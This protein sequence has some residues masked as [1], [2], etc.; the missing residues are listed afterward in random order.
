MSGEGV[1][2]S[3]SWQDPRV[4]SRDAVVLR[5]VLERHGRERGEQLF[6][7]FADGSRWTYRDAVEAARQ[8]AS[9]FA[10]LGVRQGHRV[11]SWL[12][13]GAD[14]LRVW[15][16]ANWL[17]A[18]YVP[19]NTAYRGGLLEHVIANS[20]AELLVC[21]SSLAPRLEGVALARLTTA[22]IAD[23]PA[24]GAITRLRSLG[25]GVLCEAIDDRLLMLP[26]PIEPWDEQSIIYTSGTTGPSKGVLSSYCHLATSTL[27]AFEDKDAPGMRYLLTLPLFHA[28]G[29]MGVM[30]MLLLGRSVAIPE[31]FETDR[32]WDMVRATGSTCC[33]LLGAMASFLVRQPPAAGEHDHGLHWCVIIPYTED[34]RAFSMRFGTD[35]YCM[36]NMTEVSV[37]LVSPPNPGALGSCGRIRVG[38]EARLVDANDVEVA[39]GEV[40]E[41]MLR[42][43]RPWSMNHGYNAMPDATAAAW[44]NGWFHTGD[45]F[46][47]DAA[48]DFYF[49]DRVKDAIRRRGENIS[50]FEVE[51]ECLAHPEI[52]EAAAVAVPSEYGEDEVM[53]VLAPV[54]GATPDPVGI[55]EFLRPRMAHFMLPR[56]LRFMSELP[57][58]PTAK[59]QK[60]LLRG[61]GVTVDTWDR[62]RHGI[63]VKLDPVAG[64]RAR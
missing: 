11:L 35:L 28:G 22:V 45:A 56:Y 25:G 58:T 44:R 21:H 33:T 38:V 24:P 57:K 54:V 37:P 52:L 4:P 32:F 18:S 63:Q 8:A 15:F 1:S 39:P 30:G 6:A 29:T 41:L 31:R 43:E 26:R 16:G 59:V 49:V 17:G 5:E 14:A 23:E 13:N 34:A 36:F 46:R 64:R 12:P 50:S 19:I 51:R 3:L 60:A 42:C 20:G 55:L 27:V 53:V 7:L 62:E 47:R 61:Q 48:G 40:G 9:A 2:R 10:R